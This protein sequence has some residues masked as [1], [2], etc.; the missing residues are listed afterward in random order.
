MPGGTR[1]SGAIMR[2]H[3]SGFTAVIP[4]FKRVSPKHGELFRSRDPAQIARLLVERGAKALSV[5][6][7]SE[8]FGGSAELLA[9]IVKSV[10]VPVLR[11]D[12]I[13]DEAALEDTARLGAAAVLLIVAIIGASALPG[14]HEKALALGLEPLVE[15]RAPE[16]MAAAAAVGARLVGINNRDITRL[17]KDGGSAERTAAL[18]HLAPSGAVLI[19]ESGI[20]APQDARAASRAGAHAVLVGT[21]LWLSEDMA[22][23]YESLRVP[24][25]PNTVP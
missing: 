1:F 3:A 15:A 7:E 16:E 21:A 14:L 13:T 18:A 5:V 25:A 22:K 11:K 4:D 10:D 2:E 12:F 9:Q 20:A 19:S 6:T 24:L 8:H 17:E 23:T